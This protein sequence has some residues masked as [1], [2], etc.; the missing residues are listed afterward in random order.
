MKRTSQLLLCVAASAMSACGDADIQLVIAALGFVPPATT[1]FK[2]NTP[3]DK[4]ETEGFLEGGDWTLFRGEENKW[5]LDVQDKMDFKMGEAPDVSVQ[6]VLAGERNADEPDKFTFAGRSTTVTAKPA[7]VFK[8]F[9]TH[10]V[11]I[12]LELVDAVAKGTVTVASIQRCEGPCAN[13]FALKN[14]SCTIVYPVTGMRQEI[15]ETVLAV[16]TRE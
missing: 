4:T 10:E 5:F 7:D 12:A 2:D 8:T 16:G 9:E 1:C 11:T 14:P 3:P 13:D 6:G 15:E